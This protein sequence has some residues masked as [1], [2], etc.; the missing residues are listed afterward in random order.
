M[1]T[2]Q[3]ALPY[4]TEATAMEVMLT[5]ASSK[6]HEAKQQQLFRLL[7]MYCVSHNLR[8]GVSYSP[9]PKCM[10]SQI[11]IIALCHWLANFCPLGLQPTEG[12]NIVGIQVCDLPR[13]F[14]FEY[15][16]EQ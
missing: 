1:P 16:Y 9:S 5:H 14:T 15:E 12:C 11:S 4:H 7:L 6:T 10:R 8:K 13:T 2:H 3:P